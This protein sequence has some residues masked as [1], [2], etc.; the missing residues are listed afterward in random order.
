MRPMGQNTGDRARWQIKALDR[1]G[2]ACERVVFAFE[3][4]GGQH[5]VCAAPCGGVGNRP[6]AKSVAEEMRAADD[7]QP[8]VIG[9]LETLWV[10]RR[11]P[12]SS[13][14]SAAAAA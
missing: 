2:L 12:G 7:T 4:A 13:N 11:A 6:A 14:T 9:S 1:Q 10:W 8:S 3:P 5:F